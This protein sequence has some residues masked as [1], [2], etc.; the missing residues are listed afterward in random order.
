[1]TDGD[2][3]RQDY[4]QVC[5]A[6]ALRKESSNMNRTISPPRRLR[7]RNTR[8]GLATLVFVTLLILRG[9]AVAPTR[10]NAQG[11]LTFATIGD[12]G[13]DN[14]NEQAVATMISS[15]DP[16]FILTLGDDYYTGAG[17]TG[18]GKYDESTG[19]YYCAYLKDI[20][21]TGTRCPTPGGSP[22]VNRFFPS[23][24]NHDY[25]DGGD[26]TGSPGGIT[27]YL[28][29]F[30]LPGTGFTN[31][32]G[33]ERYYD[34]VQG[35]VHLFAVN[36]NTQEPSG[37]G[38]GSAQAAWLQAQLAASTSPWNVV[39]FHHA[40]YSSSNNHGS[41]TYMQWPYAA[42]GADVVI[43]AHDHTYERI[44]RDGIVY[45][46]NGLGGN[47][48]Y[49]F[50]TPV[51]GSQFRYNANHGAQRVTADA[52]SITFEFLSVD[53]GGTLQDSVTLNAPPPTPVPT[54]TPVPSQLHVGDLDGSSAP[55]GNGGWKATVTIA[56]H[57]ASHAALS[58]VLVSGSFVKGG[59][60][61]CTTNASGVCSITSSKIP[62]SRANTTF[63]VSGAT[64][65]GYTYT[66][67][68]NH[69]PDGDS[70]GA[71]IVVSKP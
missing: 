68:A 57:D 71:S 20:A 49:G 4:R 45:F 58:G 70:T 32:S 18:T 31:S 10:T 24:G 44:N 37:T 39:Y 51:S 67:G 55:S 33:N 17:G 47:S 65:S 50:G 29:Y 3:Q 5:P 36:S 38:S 11:S 61:S 25:S 64:K 15:W 62:N 53:G 59:S 52:D 69:D 22:T 63:T 12:Y 8:W 60:G 2:A 48:A 56:V 21:T 35:P 13:V 16:T 7:S 9:L 27:N 19:A 28:A 43:G 14:A 46:V 1:V 34:Y 41:T 42:W 30:N 26:P 54:P 6:G 40:A 66:S 23:L